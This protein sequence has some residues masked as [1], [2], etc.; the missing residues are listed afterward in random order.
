MQSQHFN[1]NQ[2][3]AIPIECTNY[4]LCGG[5]AHARSAVHDDGTLRKLCVDTR[6]NG[7]RYGGL[8]RIESNAQQ[9]APDGWTTSR[10]VAFLYGV[11]MFDAICIHI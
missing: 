10:N 5:T 2:I 7:W 6:R 9:R 8:E 11:R 4:V 1:E 3:E